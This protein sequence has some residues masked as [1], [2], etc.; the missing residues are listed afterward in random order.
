MQCHSELKWGV[1][2][3]E[4]KMVDNCFTYPR[5]LITPMVVVQRMTT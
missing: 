2:M 1:L 5:D 4:D 3:S